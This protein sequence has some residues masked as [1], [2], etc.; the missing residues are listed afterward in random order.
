MEANLLNTPRAVDVS[1]FVVRAFIKLREW[2][3]AHKELA[4]KLSELERKVSGHDETIRQLVV[5]IRQLMA[6]PVS[7]K[8]KRRIGFASGRD[9]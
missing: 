1:V 6:P 4:P 5:A 3:L 7:D 9:P 8:P 2:A